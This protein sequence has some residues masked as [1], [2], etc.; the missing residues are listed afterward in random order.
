M[1]E[2]AWGKGYATEASRALLDASVATEGKKL[3]AEATVVGE[4]PASVRVLE[5]LG[6]EKVG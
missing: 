5:K 1:F 6:F 2:K 4:K 3:Y